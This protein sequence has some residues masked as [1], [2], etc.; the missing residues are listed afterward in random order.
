M[1]FFEQDILTR[2]RWAPTCRDDNRILPKAS[3]K[4][5]AKPSDYKPSGIAVIYWWY[6]GKHDGPDDSG[7]KSFRIEI[8]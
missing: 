5:S 1:R 7:T 4:R 2:I 8:K 3:V 6:K